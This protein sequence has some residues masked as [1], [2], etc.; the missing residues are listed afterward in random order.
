MS[1]VHFF[2]AS[3]FVASL[4]NSAL[5]HEMDGEWISV[6]RIS[7][8]EQQITTPSHAVI[9]D[10]KFNTVRDGQLSELGSISET[11]SETPKQYNVEMT[12]EVELS[13]ES[14]HG[15]FAISGDTMLT[16]VNPKP[17]GERP[18]AFTSTEENGNVMIV[19]IRKDT[20]VKLQE[21]ADVDAGTTPGEESK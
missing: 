9:K 12:G 18:D 14:F 20:L 2:L 15:I 10:G 11:T 13:G 17:G 1:R 8:G 16:C 6:S 7:A 3:V 5:A 19:W 4:A 21:L